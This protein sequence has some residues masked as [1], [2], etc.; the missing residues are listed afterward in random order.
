MEDGIIL[1]HFSSIIHSMFIE[2]KQFVNPFTDDKLSK[3]AN[4][5]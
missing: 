4:N 5:C 2:N 1:H 3:E